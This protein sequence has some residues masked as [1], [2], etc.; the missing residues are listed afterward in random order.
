MARIALP[1]S[2]FALAALA[3]CATP[4]YGTTA[5]PVVTSSSGTAVT[6]ASSGA[7]VTGQPVLIASGPVQPGTVIVPTSNIFRAGMGTIEAVQAV[8]IT[9]YGASASAG[10]SQPQRTA[11]RLSMKMDDGSMQAIDQSN[12][13]FRIGDRVEIRGDGTVI[14]R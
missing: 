14:R 8:H 9:P 6:T 7:V 11:Y 13:D 3:A 1:L 10:A 5:T 2:L 4:D 12:G